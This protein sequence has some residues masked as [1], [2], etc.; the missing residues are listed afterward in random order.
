[1]YQM[2]AY[3]IG[4]HQRRG[5]LICPSEEVAAGEFQVRVHDHEYVIE[6]APSCCNRRRLTCWRNCT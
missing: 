4:T 1:M 3:M 5:I 6:V 2:L